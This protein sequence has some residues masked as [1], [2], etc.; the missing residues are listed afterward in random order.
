VAVSTTTESLE[1]ILYPEITAE[2]GWLE[3]GSGHRLYFEVTGNEKGKAALFLHGGPGGETS[4]LTRR[5]FDPNCYRIVQFDQRGAGRSTPHAS[6]CENTTW[7]LVDDIERLRKQ[8]DIENF[9]VFGGSWGSALALAYAISYPERIRQLVLRGI[10]LLRTNE[11]RWFYQSGV[12]RL[13]PQ[14]WEEF[15]SLLSKT[16]RK[17]VIRSYYSRLTSGDVPAAIQA[18]RAWTFWEKR[19]SYI[20]PRREAELSQ[21]SDQYC[22]AFASI[23]SHYFVHRGFF[24]SDSWVFDQTERIR[25]IPT[26]IVQGQYDVVCPAITAWELHSTLPNSSLK[27]VPDAGHSAFE[28]GI[29]KELV[30]ATDCFR[31]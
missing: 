9:L 12:H 21:L 3:V 7:D 17:S 5:F 2:E 26:V 20:V 30:A 6:L 4:S 13:F 22:L 8:L 15:I 31:A 14:Y 24:K 27:L 23:E 19:L 28:I 10:F 25:H 18:A 16:E 11:L 29:A 1:S